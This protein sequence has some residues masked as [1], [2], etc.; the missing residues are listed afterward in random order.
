MAAGN[1]IQ[2]KPVCQSR[3]LIDERP[4]LDSQNVQDLVVF[5]GNILP[6]EVSGPD[7]GSVG[8][9]GAA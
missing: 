1:S 9:Q 8:F 4:A 7:V 6:H 3:V 5:A 2:E